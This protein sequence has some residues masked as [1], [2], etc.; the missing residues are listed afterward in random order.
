MLHQFRDFPKQLSSTDPLVCA[1][2]RLYSKSR[3]EIV[4]FVTKHS[5]A[6]NAGRRIVSENIA[7][8]HLKY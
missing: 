6:H 2:L 5:H 4:L 3:G 1:W 8:F 7:L